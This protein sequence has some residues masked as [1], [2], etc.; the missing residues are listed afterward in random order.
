LAE[1][2]EPI[3]AEGADLEVVMGYREPGQ[4]P[5][6]VIEV[7]PVKGR[8]LTEAVEGA[9]LAPSRI[10]ALLVSGRNRSGLAHTV[11]RAIADA[12]INLSFL[13]AQKVGAHYSA[14]FGFET[15]LDANRAMG[16]IRKAA[17]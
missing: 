14:V 8:R 5:K 10:P 1:V 16:L 17:R 11:A 2:L 7:Y 4:P 15:E 6:A 13:V 12:G 9:G 3:A